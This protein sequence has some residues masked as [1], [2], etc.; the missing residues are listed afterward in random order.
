MGLQGHKFNTSPNTT[1]LLLYG[2]N[3][4]EFITLSNAVLKLANVSQPTS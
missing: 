3:E 2:I 1:N 4:V